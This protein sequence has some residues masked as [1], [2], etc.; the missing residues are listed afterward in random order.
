MKEFLKLP[1]PNSAHPNAW[2]RNII[3]V[4]LIFASCFGFL[5]YI[6]S[7]YLAWKQKLGEVVILDT[8][9][10]LL[11]WFLLLLP[12][13]F[14]KPKSYSL[15]SLVF[16]LG[17]LLYTKIGLGG[18]GILWL[19]LV[20]VFCGIFLNQT[21]AFWGWAVASICVF[22]G[23]L[24]SHY[25]I[26]IESSETP[27]QILVVGA[28]FTFLCGILT[29][30]TTTILKKLGYEMRK[31][32]ELVLL[33]K[34]TIQK[35]RKEIETRATT[36]SELT[37]SLNEKET[38]FREIQ[39]RV[40]NN[41]HLILGIMTLEQQKTKSEPAQK[42][43]ESAMNRIQAMGMVQDYLFLKNSYRSVYA[44]DYINSLVDHIFLSYGPNDGSIQL[45]RNVEEIFLP[46]EKAIP[47]G[48]IINEAISNSFKHAFPNHHSG[49]ISVSFQKSASG[50]L[51][52]EI[53]D[54]G[55]GKKSE[56][57][58]SSNED[59]LGI[60]LIEALCLQLRAKLEIEKE[61][62]FSVRVRFFP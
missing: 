16:I 15:L 37:E 17:C 29:L 53:A 55:I 24:F 49:K 44:K 60:S 36:E 18:A 40:K 58:E 42:A 32:K 21:F 41:I 35:L 43:I 7:V 52:L 59:P 56:I 46:V 31:Q 10:L 48:L 57:K 3:H 54:N 11:V 8:L 47:C 62:G 61:N 12:N 26:W 22:S 4:L 30:L 19:L 1:S 25:Q 23:V 20:P 13:R 45:D 38:L 33:Q 51:T 14:Y 5:I 39:H 2:K 28:N 27:F 34:K 9:A 6:P 50:Y